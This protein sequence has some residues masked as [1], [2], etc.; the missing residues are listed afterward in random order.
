MVV[1]AAGGKQEAGQVHCHR[2]LLS[3]TSHHLLVTDP[4]VPLEKVN[5]GCAFFQGGSQLLDITTAV[6]KRKVAP[7]PDPETEA[8]DA[9]VRREP[10][11]S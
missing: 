6:I 3:T 11:V 4:I 10:K 2:C 8:K 1:T 7:V 9:L 5:L